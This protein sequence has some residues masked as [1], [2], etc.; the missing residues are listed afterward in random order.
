MWSGNIGRNHNHNEGWRQPSLQPCSSSL[1][2][3][4]GVTLC[5]ATFFGSE[6]LDTCS[7]LARSSEKAA[8]KAASLSGTVFPLLKRLLLDCSN[9]DALIVSM[10]SRL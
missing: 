5:T 2:E 7:L 10:F 8:S 1:S 4:V 9:E 6:L 3:R